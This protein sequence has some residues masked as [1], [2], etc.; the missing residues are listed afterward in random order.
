MRKPF[1]IFLII[2]LFFASMPQ[3]ILSLELQRELN[4]AT[5][6]TFP[7][8]DSADTTAYK[9]SAA[10]L[11]SETTNW[12]DQAAAGS[13]SDCTNEATEIDSTG[14]YT[15]ALTAGEMNNPY[16]AIKVT[17]TSTLTQTILIATRS[18]N[19]IYATQT[20]ISNLND[21]STAQV[22]TEVDTALSDL[23]LDHLM[24]VAVV[25]TDVIDNSVFAKLV[26]KSA[27]ADWDDFVNTTDSLQAIKDLGDS[28]WI[29]A[30]GF[31]TH[32]AAD[33]WTSAT[34]TLTAFSLNAGLTAAAIDSI[35]DEVQ[36]GHSTA[37]TFG[38]YLDAVVSGATAPTAAAVADQVWDELTS[39]HA[40]SGSTGEALSAAG[41]AGDPWITA[42]PG[43]YSS[44]QAGKI[45]GDMGTTQTSDS[46]N[47]SAIKTRVDALNP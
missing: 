9:S 5:Y 14:I 10:S 13:F 7:L 43:S 27:T 45:I 22:N 19:Q 37:G 3:N 21:I 26:S 38:L 1:S 36:S 40:V 31:S 12:D 46:T 42:L 4:T 44:G 16:I 33:V 23:N 15:L 28:A 17:A 11:D 6:I 24:K 20:D 41:T 34:R 39:G 25:G 8:I 35:W 2:L 32:S 47:I 30:T 18:I 29:T